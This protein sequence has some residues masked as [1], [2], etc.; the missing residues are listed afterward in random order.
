MPR[1]QCLLPLMYMHDGVYCLLSSFFVD[2]SHLLVPWACVININQPA[3]PCIFGACAGSKIKSCLLPFGKVCV[4]RSAIPLQTVAQVQGRSA[5][6]TSMLQL[7]TCR[8]HLQ[9]MEI[10]LARAQLFMCQH[11]I[12]S[13]QSWSGRTDS[14]RV[15]P[16]R[17][18]VFRRVETSAGIVPHIIRA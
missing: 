7:H 18:Y 13:Q 3:L 10:C 12:M 2:T 15:D 8:I 17:G 5:S 6:R 16:C 4:L 11:H 14:W 9:R 1:V